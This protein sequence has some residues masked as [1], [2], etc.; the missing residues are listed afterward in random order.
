[1]NHRPVEVDCSH[2]CVHIDVLRFLA[3]HQQHRPQFVPVEASVSI[4][5]DAAVQQQQFTALVFTKGGN[6]LEPPPNWVQGEVRPGL[7]RWGPHRFH[8]RSS[9]CSFSKNSKCAAHSAGSSHTVASVAA[10]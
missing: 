5:I 10:W 6:K 7:V 4:Q 8:T 9:F 2:R 1:M 3:E